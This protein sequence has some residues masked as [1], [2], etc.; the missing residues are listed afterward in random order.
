[1]IAFVLLSGG[2]STRMGKGADKGLMKLQNKPLIQYALEL[3]KEFTNA[4]NLDKEIPVK[5]CL[6][7][8]IQMDEY[9]NA[10]PSLKEEQCIVDEFV[11]NKTFSDIPK[12]QQESIFGLWSSMTELRNDYKNIFFLPCDAPLITEAVLTELFNEYF[13]NDFPLK[14]WDKFKKPTYK[15][16]KLNNP[17]I[18]KKTNG[19]TKSLMKYKSYIPQWDNNKYE[20]L[21]SIYH[22]KS[23]LP[24][25]ERKILSK[26]YLLQNI[27]EEV[28]ENPIISTIDGRKYEVEIIPIPIEDKFGSDSGAHHNF[29]DI[30][31]LD[32]FKAVE[33]LILKKK[34][35]N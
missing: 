20:P 9:L 31:S 4:L 32:N 27:L 29:I 8:Y 22:I 19:T 16:N 6:H 23:F 26:Q 21:F 15:H 1:M 17:L 5:V 30:N 24:I 33:S 28:K 10:V 25:I 35:K 2:A 18:D 12:P 11:W 34:K 13:K 14:K 3:I 7:D